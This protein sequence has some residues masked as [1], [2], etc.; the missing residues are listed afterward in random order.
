[1][2]VLGGCC[3]CSIIRSCHSISSISRITN[4][5]NWFGVCMGRMRPRSEIISRGGGGGSSSLIDVAI[6]DSGQSSSVL[7][8]TMD[9]FRVFKFAT[10]CCFFLNLLFFFVPDICGGID[11]NMI[12]LPVLPHHAL[13]Q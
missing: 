7:V 11:E 5:A 12:T 10:S 8:A 1:V 2:V 3:G 6:S 4:V 13:F 9:R